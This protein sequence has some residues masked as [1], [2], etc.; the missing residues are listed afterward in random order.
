[1]NRQESTQ[2]YIQ[3]FHLKHLYVEHYSLITKSYRESYVNIV[4]IVKFLQTAI[5]WLYPQNARPL[6]FEEMSPSKNKGE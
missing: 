5:F 3:R 1:M 6:K 2:D 4:N